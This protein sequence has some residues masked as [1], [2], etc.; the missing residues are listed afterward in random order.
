MRIRMFLAAALLATSAF[1][2]V[3]PGGAPMGPPS[4][5]LGEGQWSAGLEY[6]YEQTNLKASGTVTQVFLNDSV[7]WFTA[8]F[9]F[10]DVT[11]N[12]IFGTL[13]FGLTDTW[14]IFA[15][16][17]AANG[18]DSLVVPAYDSEVSQTQGDFDGKFGFAGGAG[19]RATFFQSGPWSFGGLLQVTWFQPGKSS[20]SLDNGSTTGEAKLNYWQTQTSLAV[21]Y[22]ADQWRFWAGPFLQFVRGDLKFDSLGGD[23]KSTSVAAKVQE[24]SQIG[25]H[26]GV[27]WQ[28]CDNFNAWVEGQV[29]ADSWL[30]GVGAVF[31]PGKT[32]EL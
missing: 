30:V 9:K 29:T 14:D 25:G 3:A 10:E 12:M 4:A 32:K 20:L 26:F 13:S 28:A 11:S 21:A 23:V 7:H 31:I 6:G 24:E 27:L 19:T 16:A 18:K 22:Q 8:P 17:G 2:S 1:V 5:Y 15:R